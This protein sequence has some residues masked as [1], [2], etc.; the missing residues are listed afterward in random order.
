MPSDS[1]LNTFYEAI[2]DGKIPAAI[3]VEDGLAT[4]TFD[5]NL[6]DVFRM[7]HGTEEQRAKLAVYA[8]NAARSS[9]SAELGLIPG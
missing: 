3:P 9:V 7:A 5:Q 6:P 4:V 8:V 2:E 1:A